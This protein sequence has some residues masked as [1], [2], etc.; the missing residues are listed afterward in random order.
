LPKDRTNLMTIHLFSS[1]PMGEDAR[2]CPVDS[3]GRVRG[4]AGLHVADGSLIP[5]APGVNPQATIMALAYR[6]AE[7]ALEGGMA[8]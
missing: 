1:C 4:V 3:F 5:E 7:H 2:R 6:C 8:R